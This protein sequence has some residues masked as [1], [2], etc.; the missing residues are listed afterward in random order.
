MNKQG[1]L[2]FRERSSELLI[3]GV[4]RI[5]SSK[6]VEGIKETL[7]LYAGE[8]VKPLKLAGLLRT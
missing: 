8:F 3:A 6:A 7:R 5:V 4:E 1:Y 2:R